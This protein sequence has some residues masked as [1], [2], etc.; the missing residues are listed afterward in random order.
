M[1]VI[2]TKFGQ[3]EVPEEHIYLFPEGILGFS[4]IKRYAIV[5]SPKG[6]PFQWMHAVESAPLS[7]VVCDPILFRP[8]YRIFVRR[9]DIAVIHLDDISKGIVLVIVTIPKDPQEMTANLQGPLLF[10]PLAKLAKQLVLNDPT[11]TVRYKIIGR[12]TKGEP[13]AGSDKTN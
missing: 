3:I 5:Q 12:E 6:G 10:N 11:Y 13:D 9:E 1:V 8:D 7:F 2:A 4:E